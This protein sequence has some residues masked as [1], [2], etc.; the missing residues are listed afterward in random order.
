M[1]AIVPA[2]LYSIG[3]YKVR[4][5]EIKEIEEIYKKGF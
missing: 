3:F 5:K 2:V 1:V 4:K